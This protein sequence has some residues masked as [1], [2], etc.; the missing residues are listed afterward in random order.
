MVVAFPAP[1]GGAERWPPYDTA[2]WAQFVPS[3]PLK[4]TIYLFDEKRREEERSIRSWRWVADGAPPAQNDEYKS[5]NDSKYK[6]FADYCQNF[7]ISFC[8]KL[9]PPFLPGGDQPLLS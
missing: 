2:R 3:V 7:I 9:T 6:T 5:I 8:L 4:L 1:L